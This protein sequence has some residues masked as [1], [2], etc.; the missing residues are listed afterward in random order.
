MIPTSPEGLPNSEAFQQQPKKKEDSR[1]SSVF[2]HPGLGKLSACRVSGRPGLQET[3]AEM[4]RESVATTLFQ[5][6]VDRKGDRDTNV[7]HSLRDR[8]I[9]KRSLNGKLTW[10][11]EE[12]EKLSK[13]FIRL[14][15]RLRREIGKREILISHVKRS[16][17]NVNLC[18]FSYIKQVDGQIRLREIRLVCD[19]NWN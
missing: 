2:G 13:N 17:K 14:R 16:I 15:L 3:G 11:S 4:D 6:T 12:R 10:P 9:S 7:A 18:D 1:V 5:F 8:K 19:E